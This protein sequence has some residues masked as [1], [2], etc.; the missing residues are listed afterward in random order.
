M[1][2]HV[3]FDDEVTQRYVKRGSDPFFTIYWTHEQAAY[4][5]P[6]W[7]D[8]GSVILSWWLVAAKSLLEGAVEAELPFMDGP[9]Q[10]NV[11]RDGD[12]LYVSPNDL[13]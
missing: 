12:L 6:Q 5:Q 3:E 9:F 13:A 7:K 11:R 10:L 4:P 2:L 8:F 1:K